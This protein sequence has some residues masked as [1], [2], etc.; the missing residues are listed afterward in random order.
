MVNKKTA[1]RRER[2]IAARKE[3]IL[4]AAA[5]VF[6]EKGF[7]RATTKEI[8]EAADVSEGT[9]YNYFGS[10]NDLLIGLMAHVGESQAPSEV[11]ERGALDDARAFYTTLLRRRH[12]FTRQNKSILQSILSE[13]LTNREM[14]DRYN[15]QIIEP[16]L[17]MFGQY[18]SIQVEQGRVRQMDPEL[19]TRF[20]FALNLG[21]LGM[22]ILG[23]PLIESKWES[24]ELLESLV[25]FVFDGLANEGAGE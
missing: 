1:A 24:D 10:K 11:F 25:G 14:R 20:L 4:D 21:M 17:S 12:A 13:I 15:E 5:R 9:I 23:D 2:R 7:H 3:Q 19:L 6:A 18:V 22:L 16:Y 8:A